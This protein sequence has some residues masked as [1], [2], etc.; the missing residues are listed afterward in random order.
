M[1]KKTAAVFFA[2]LVGMAGISC[3]T[4]DQTSLRSTLE[5]TW[6]AHLQASRSGKESELEKTMS[7][8]R[9]GEMKNNL[10][11]AKRSLTPELIRSIAEYAPDIT[12]AKFVTLLEK[13]P[14]S[15]LVYIK[16]SEEKDAAGKPRVD[17]IFIKFVKEASGW[18]VDAGMNIDRPKFQDDGK[19]TEFDPSD[20]EPSY[21]IDGEV[22]TA[23]EPVT[24][25]YASALL[26]VF[27]RGYS[28]QV[29]V[30]GN[31]QET[32]VDTSFSG[33]LKGGLRKGENSI[34]IVI[35]RT[36]E[37]GEFEPQVTVRRILEDRKIEDVF[38]FEPK[39][40][41]EG[42]HTFTFMIDKD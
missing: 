16:D 9:F 31:E 12:E 2:L 32:S 42:K 36:K 33:L 28:V 8:F 4:D 38:K 39:K 17:F 18:K 27:C 7:S 23:P 34:V 1:I 30:N 24:P 37:G 6:T 5:Q 11:A 10:A 19:E 29:T 21:R 14:T 35:T 41:I 3:G 22:R 13:G 26:D 20:L 40:T 25:P 15:G